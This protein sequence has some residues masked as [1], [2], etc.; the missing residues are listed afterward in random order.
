MTTDNMQE[1][2]FDP[3]AV[4]GID[5]ASVEQG[6]AK[7]PVVQWHSGNQ[8]LKKLGG[9]DYAGGFFVKDGAI[10]SE[11][12]TANGWTKTDLIHKDGTST[13]G[14]MRREMAVSV[15]A[16]RQRWEVK[17]T[18][19]PTQVFPWSGYKDA[20]RIGRPS[21]KTQALCIVKGLESAGPVML[22]FSGTRA[23]SFT[24]SNKSSGALTKFSQTVITAAN[25][26]SDG[27]AKKAGKPLGKH[28]PYRAFWLPI[29]ANR[30]G[31]GD[32]IFTE[33]GSGKDT[34]YVVLPVALGL[35]EKPD[36]VDLRKFY[37]GNDMLNTVNALYIDN[38]DW[39]TAW[40]SIIPGATDNGVTVSEPVE[41]KADE[42]SAVLAAAGL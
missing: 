16:I 28:W 4:D 20:E 3:T 1:M 29:G 35:P 24:G 2:D 15:I 10:N 33:V 11:L 27:A 34:S 21:G 40:E 32:P 38:A 13:E 22:T 36:Q 17:Q 30:D 37:V 9:A 12:L 25:Q 5:Q 23:V 8:A 26:A 6:G 39:R 41:P 42:N 18:N 14:W 31:K 7:F 19:A